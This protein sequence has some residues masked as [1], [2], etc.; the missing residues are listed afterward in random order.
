MNKVYSKNGQSVDPLLHFFRR[1]LRGF[2]KYV[3]L[4]ISANR[5]YT[6]CTADSISCT[7]NFFKTARKGSDKMFGKLSANR[8][9]A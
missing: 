5:Q 7:G 4:R 3:S 1:Q 6:G 2:R 8:E 9:K